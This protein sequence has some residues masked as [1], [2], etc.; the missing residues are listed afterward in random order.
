MASATAFDLFD[1]ML[2][3]GKVDRR[4]LTALGIV[5]SSDYTGT[6]ERVLD[7]DEGT[8]FDFYMESAAGQQIFFDVKRSGD[9]FRGCDNDTSHHE[10]LEEHYRPHLRDHVDA[11]WLAPAAFCAN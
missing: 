11:K 5:D 4:L 10:K 2:D 3:R 9:Q 6:F 7:A 1:P 8:S